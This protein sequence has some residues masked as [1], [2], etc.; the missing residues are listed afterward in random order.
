MIIAR[1]LGSHVF[2]GAL[3][4]LLT[5]VSLSLFFML[6]R[7][8]DD[9]GTGNYDMKTMLQ[10]LL[11]KLPY[12]VVDFMPLA[13]LIGCILSL[14]NLAGNSEII[15]LQASGLSVEKLIFSIMVWVFMLAI[16]SF[17]IAEFIV[18]VSETRARDIRLSS[19]SSN[20]SVHARQGVWIKDANNVIYIERLFPDGNGSNI[21]IYQLDDQQR[22]IQALHAKKALISNR[23]WVLQDIDVSRF[24]V[25]NVERL[26]IDKQLYHGNLSDT[27][28]ESLSVNPQQMSISDLTTY[29]RFLDEN[30]LDSQSESLFLW[31]KVYAPLGVLIMGLLA[32]PFVLGSQRQSN[33][34]QRLVKGILLG[35]SYFV[36]ERLFIQTGEQMHIMA[37][38]NAL[39][40]SLIFLGLAGWLI[41]QKITFN[42]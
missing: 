14:G 39:I 41:Y 23:G 3:L 35:L 6:I 20:I 1:Y 42:R 10:F 31:R 12:Y 37:S 5:L 25:Q 34:G 36:V 30:N 33:T 4:V 11:L 19:L 2:R 26:H 8:L 17:L 9:V 28:L 29:I 40:P 22:L 32:V 27:L 15:A 38:I 24:H 16:V 13:I 18:P 7:E 21:K